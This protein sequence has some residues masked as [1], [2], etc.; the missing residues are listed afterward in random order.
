MARPRRNR[1]LKLSTNDPKGMW[2]GTLSLRDACVEAVVRLMKL[3]PSLAS[4]VAM[5]RDLVSDLSS[6]L[7]DTTLDEGPPPGY[8]FGMDG[9][10]IDISLRFGGP[11]PQV[12]FEVFTDAKIDRMDN[13]VKTT[14]ARWASGIRVAKRLEK[15]YGTSLRLFDTVAELLE[16][17]EG[18]D[19]SW[20][21]A[22]TPLGSVPQVQAYFR[23][24]PEQMP[25]VY[26]ATAA[27]GIRAFADK[28][29]DRLDG[30]GVVSLTA[31]EMTDTAPRVK[32]YVPAGDVSSVE[33]LR[34]L[35]GDFLPT[36][37]LRGL[38]D[39]FYGDGVEFVEAAP[40]CGF[41]F[42]GGVM[43]GFTLYLPTDQFHLNLKDDVVLTDG[44]MT[45]RIRR[46]LSRYGIREEEYLAALRA[47]AVDDLQDEVCVQ[48]CFSFIRD[49]HGL[50]ATVYLSPRFFFHQF[51]IVA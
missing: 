11:T 50:Q 12:R 2:P 51:G 16:P 29:W 3:Y 43:T 47:Y 24:S 15:N 5:A 28:L 17:A 31:F 38:F 40:L 4:D 46:V 33:N 44:E 6:E 22:T 36:D 7:P 20:F 35:A 23:S 32:V 18:G 13:S 39:D 27:L 30:K 48:H 42:R 34:D 49:N 25:K 26:E 19:R 21:G 37:D 41:H 9:T 8:Y 1:R 10:P 45:E 14:A